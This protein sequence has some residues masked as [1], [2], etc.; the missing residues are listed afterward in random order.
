[1]RF[2]LVLFFLGQ[3]F[4]ESK[5]PDRWSDRE[6]E[7][8]RHDSPWAQSVGPPPKV[9][10]YLA[11]AAPIEEAEQEDASKGNCAKHRAGRPVMI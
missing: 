10:V 3:P 11:T 9:L 5:P 4:W 1:M 7:A 2:L 8:I 6:I